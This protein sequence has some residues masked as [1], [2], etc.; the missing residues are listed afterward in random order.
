MRIVRV[1]VQVE[2]PC[3]KCGGMMVRLSSA[4]ITPDG[5]IGE[6]DPPAYTS[7]CNKCESKQAKAAKKLLKQDRNRREWLQHV[8]PYGIKGVLNKPKGRA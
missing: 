2:L 7:I 4:G 6:P 1:L 8:A 3:P 5:R